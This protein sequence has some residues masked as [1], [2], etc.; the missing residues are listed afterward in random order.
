[1]ASLAWYAHRLRAM[2]PTEL[3]WRARN[4]LRD[5][6]DRWLLGWRSR[7]AARPRRAAPGSRNGH[8]LE[9]AQLEVGGWANGH[10]SAWQRAAAERL[11]GRADRIQAGRLSLFDLEDYAVGS[12]LDWNREPKHCVPVP[13]RFAPRV[14]YRDFRVAGDAKF[15]WEPNRHHQLVVLGRAYRATGE[16][17]YAQAVVAQWERWLEQCPFGLGI[18]WRSPLELAIRLINWVWTLDLI[19]PAGV[20]TPRLQERILSAAHLHLWEISRKY[21]RGSSANNHRIGEAAGVYVGSCYFHE[22]RGA[23]RWREQSRQMLCAEMLAQTYPDGGTREQAMGYQLFVLQFFVLAA[24]LARRVGDEFPA[25]YGARLREMFEFVGA[26]REG[27]DHLPMLG[28][29]DDGYVLDLDADPHDVRPWLAIGAVLLREPKLKCRAGPY[30]E[31]AHWLLGPESEAEYARLETFASPRPLVSRAFANSGYYLLQSGPCDSPARIS[32]LFDCGRLGFRSIAAHGHADA[33]S[34][35]LRA[36]GRDVLVDPG[37]YDYFT[38]PTW[39]DYFRST[40]AHNTVT[41]DDLDQSVMLGPFLWGARARARCVEWAPAPCGGRV[42]GEH[43]GYCRLPNPVL[44]RRM[45]EVDGERREVRIADELTG[46]GRHQAAVYFHLAE[47]CRLVAHEGNR[48]EIDADGGRVRIELDARLTTEVLCASETPIAGWVSRGYH[49]KAPS[50][51][52][53]GRAAFTGTQRW[54]TRITIGPPTATTNASASR[55]EAARQG[56]NRR[57][58]A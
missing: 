46:R 7:R 41:V 30:A 13:R 3:A 33:L 19:A 11:G 43:N 8:R 4:T 18:N 47:H 20:V 12:P 10:C 22:L 1:M 37:T 31:G 56:D 9:L 15:I 35:T 5:F 54:H 40:R 26:L 36:F 53:I 42:A 48:F 44:H 49:R 55:D 32:V 17:G 57:V 51:T 25:T 50:V 24:A 38:Y 34:V 14:D 23:P 2:A 39:R 16:L 58:R 6:V 45:V 28:D 29:S 27:G 52:I 21:S